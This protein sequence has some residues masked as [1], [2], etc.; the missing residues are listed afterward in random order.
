MGGVLLPGCGS[1][2]FRPVFFSKIQKKNYD[3]NSLCH[4]VFLVKWFLCQIIVL[5]MG[6]VKIG[7]F[8]ELPCLPK[9]KTFLFITP[10]VPIVE[11]KTTCDSCL[12]GPW[13]KKIPLTPKNFPYTKKTGICIRPLNEKIWGYGSGR[14]LRLKKEFFHTWAHN[15]LC[16][17][18]R[19]EWIFMDG[20][21]Q[22]GWMLVGK[23]PLPTNLC[24]L[25]KKKR[26]RFFFFFFFFAFRC[27]WRKRQG[28]CEGCKWAFELTF[29][30]KNIHTCKRISPDICNYRWRTSPTTTTTISW[31]RRIVMN[32]SLYDYYYGDWTGYH[33]CQE[34][35]AG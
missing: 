31:T 3:K 35:D 34:N 22:Q 1:C 20:G 27:L 9:W 21:T 8:V 13:L 26:E 15:L 30:P 5:H 14:K 19:Y 29:C 25:K 17:S 7:R 24:R 18:Q 11:L 10:C 32:L 16:F 33:F 28:T 6:K 23:C 2:N 4:H 12:V